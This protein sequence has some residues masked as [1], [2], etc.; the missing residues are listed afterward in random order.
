MTTI[1]LTEEQVIYLDMYILMT[2]GM[3]EREL[4]ACERL[5][6][7]T[8]EDGTLK[9]PKMPA[10]AKWW[11]KTHELMEQIHEILMSSESEVN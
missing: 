10:N 5:A 3:R 1:T 11:R 6:K 4:A 9:Y 7:E 2:T 8:N